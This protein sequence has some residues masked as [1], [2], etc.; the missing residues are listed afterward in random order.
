MCSDDIFFDLLTDFPVHLKTE[1]LDDL[2]NTESK[3]VLSKKLL[4]TTAL[5]SYGGEDTTN[6]SETIPQANFN[7]E[8]P[9]QTSPHDSHKV[10]S[11]SVACSGEQ[12]K[13]GPRKRKEPQS[14]PFSPLPTGSDCSTK[15]S[16][17]TTAD[18]SDLSGC[19]STDMKPSKLHPYEDFNSFLIREGGVERERLARLVSSQDYPRPDE[20]FVSFLARSIGI[21]D[22]QYVAN[23]RQA[24]RCEPI[25]SELEPQFPV[26][27]EAEEAALD[28]LPDEDAMSFLLRSGSWESASTLE[29]E[30]SLVGPRKDEDA[31][32]FLRRTGNLSTASLG[33]DSMKDMQLV[34]PGMSSFITARQELH[35]LRKQVLVKV[36]SPSEPMKDEVLMKENSPSTPTEIDGVVINRKRKSPDLV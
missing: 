35:M 36:S 7:L 15:S 18:E 26:K 16:V 2:F 33:L 19:P 21:R 9:S 34:P 8:D 22:E 32:T 12:V 25:H 11:P 10:L 30:L 20:D 13:M 4:E 5:L 14:D 23:L 29:E 28:I 1:P 3:P 17:V 31:E 24:L 6:N 27:Q